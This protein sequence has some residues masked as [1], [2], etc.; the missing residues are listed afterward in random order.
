MVQLEPLYSVLTSCFFMSSENRLSRWT[1][2]GPKAWLLL[3]LSVFV[4][5]MLVYR[6][7]VAPS[8]DPETYVLPNST[9]SEA[10]ISPVEQP[11]AKTTDSKGALLSTDPL[12]S[13][14][15]AAPVPHVINHVIKSGE[16][17]EKIFN[18]LGLSRSVM[19]SILEADEE[20]L[21]LDPLLAGDTLS[22]ELDDEGKLKSL[23]R[24]IN[25]SKSIS[26][27][28]HDNGGYS[29]QEN[30]LPINYSQE[31]LHG[32]IAGSFYQS[33]KKLG[34]SDANIV[35]IS[36]LFKTRIDFRKDPR[37]GDSFDVVVETGDVNGESVGKMQLEAIQ[38]TIK[39]ET[40]HAFLHS[41]GRFYDQNGNGLTPALL[42]WPTKIH[43][44]ISSPFNPNRRHPITGRLSPHNGTDLAA[45]SGTK[46]LATGD[47]VV[48][49]VAYQKYAGKYLDVDNLGPYSTRFLHLSKILVKKGQHV[50]RGQV[51]ALSGNTGRT[52]G[53]HLHYELHVNGKPVNAMTT[54]IPTLQE[55]PNAKMPEFK[56][57]VEQ[58]VAMMNDTPY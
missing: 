23:S 27:L 45:P 51:I 37:A 57:H 10:E 54:D 9:M 15:S 32:K 36:D 4:L 33:A 13:V 58:W 12:Q 8:P 14:V 24:R 21:V 25:P 1:P 46:V 47:G 17:L 29:Y 38:L 55:I 16:T 50:K 35:I 43:Y 6:A 34:L 52:T 40:Y 42:R 30:A 41:D 19:Y 28:R 5:L 3:I 39:G 49:R 26:Y 31:A 7:L 18:R 44:R 11:A 20:Y 2:S 48:T 22:F 53:A 56:R